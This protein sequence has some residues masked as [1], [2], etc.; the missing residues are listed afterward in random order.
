MYMQVAK[1]KTSQGYMPSISLANR[2]LQQ[3]MDITHLVL[4]WVKWPNGEKLACKFDRD[5]SECK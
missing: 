4:T 5:G 3:Q 2:L 1:R